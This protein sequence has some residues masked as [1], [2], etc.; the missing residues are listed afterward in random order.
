MKITIEC[1]QCGATVELIKKEGLSWINLRPD[2]NNADIKIN[3]V[4]INNLEVEED[5]VVGDEVN[6]E[7]ESIELCCRNCLHHISINF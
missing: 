3:D 1:T 2:Y 4:N 7:L 6:A 5:M